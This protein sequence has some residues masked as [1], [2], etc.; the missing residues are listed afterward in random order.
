[1][2]TNTY[3]GTEIHDI[4]LADLRP[5]PSNPRR[6]IGDVTDL[7]A[8]IKANGL[9]S[10][11]S[12]VPDPEDPGKYLIIAGH[13]RYT[14]AKQAKLDTVPAFILHLDPRQQL[15]AM[16]SENT[17]REQL[18]LIEEAD[19]CQGLLD[20]GATVKEIGR[21]IGRSGAYV[22]SRLKIAAIPQATRDAAKDFDTLTL[23]QLDK[24]T[25][26]ADDPEAQQKLAQTGSR[27]FDYMYQQLLDARNTRKWMQKALIRSEA[28]GITIH[29]M[30][31]GKQAW[32][33]TP[34]GTRFDRSF[35]AGT[36]GSFF[37]QLTDHYGTPLPENIQLW[38]NTDRIVAYKTIPQDEID[39]KNR[40]TQA[41]KEAKAKERE[42][43][44]KTRK[45]DTISRKTRIEWARTLNPGDK[46]RAKAI[47]A[48]AALEFVGTGT[49]LGY[50]R[51]RSTTIIECYNQISRQPLPVKE[52]DQDHYSLDCWE[53]TQEIRKRCNTNPHH[54]LT[55]MIARQ[56][57]DITTLTWQSELKQA[58][59]Y[60]RIIQDLGY[61]PSDEEKQALAGAYLTT[62]ES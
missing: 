34:E 19:A 10:P 52:K 51:P 18:T 48:L 29:T 2:T 9:L 44:A 20:L 6:D 33:F 12:V 8:S 32:N 23:D 45:F 62:K 11:I 3:Q 37:K 55:L 27:N 53:N 60:Y 38:A 43:N 15:E 40:Q 30:P 57:A 39:Q 49:Y 7:A 21:N 25:E 36:E 1:M 35:G 41:Q 56:E 17:Q 14:A 61:E 59:A 46:Q 26:F 42:R 4:A 24:I 13:R 28:A 5:H 31:D 54:I 16:I 22:R 47:E 50:F 58:Q